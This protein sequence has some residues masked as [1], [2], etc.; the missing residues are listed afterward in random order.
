[1]EITN[2]FPITDYNE[3]RSLSEYCRELRIHYT[4]KELPPSYFALP[5][6]ETKPS[7]PVTPQELNKEIRHLFPFVAKNETEFKRHIGILKEYYHFK[8][9]PNDYIR[10]RRRLPK[11]PSELKLNKYSFPLTD[12]TTVKDFITEIE[13]EYYI[14][15]PLPVEYTEINFTNK[16]ELPWDFRKIKQIKLNIPITSPKELVSTARNLRKFYFFRTIPQTW[17]RIPKKEQR[18]F[19]NSK[20]KLPSDLQSLKESIK[21]TLPDLSIDLP[22]TD[23]DKV[24]ATVDL[25][26]EN[27]DFQTTPPYLF[28]LYDQPKPEWDLYDYDDV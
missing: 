7:L 21:N 18:Q 4:F 2:H 16:P 23:Y 1:M 28:E 20:P 5:E 11:E 22:I 9:L 6:V 24:I 3:L 17:I 8:R 10:Q 25:L 19:T 13:D 26:R 14:P 27:F 15:E 12:P